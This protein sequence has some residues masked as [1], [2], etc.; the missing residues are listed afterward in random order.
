MQYCFVEGSFA[1]LARELAEYLH[2]EVGDN[3][4]AN[5]KDEVLK[6]LVTAS[7]GLNSYPEKEF[8]A[9]YNLLVYLVMQSPSVNMF[10][11]RIC[12]NLSKPITS[13]PVN[14]AGLALNVLTTIFNLLQPD[15]EVRSNV[16]TAI[17]RLVKNS[18][19]FETLRPQLKKLDTWI[20]EWDLDEEDQRKL[21]GQLAD[22]AEENGEQGESYQYVLKALRTFESA[23][24]SSK[25]AQDL[26]LRALK[27]A[28][29]STTHFDFHDLTSLPT[30]QALSDDHSEY[31]ELLEIFSEKELEDYNDFRDENEDWLETEGLDNSVLHRKMRLLTL[32][33]VAASTNSKEL[34]YKRIAKALQIPVEDVEM[35]VIDVIRAGLIE[36]KLSQQ[37]QV[38]L[39][40]RTTYRVFGEKQWREVATRLD[41]WRSSLRAVKEVISRERQQ[42]EAQKERELHEA[43][44]K[45]AGASGMGAG[46][47]TIGGRENMVEMGTD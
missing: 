35:W 24:Y 37:K 2:V 4:D 39:I 14:G 31:S 23:E 38:F 3:L 45:I 34:E 36:G 13:A 28:L 26:S 17:L 46:R 47:R 30:I 19:N 22:V 29:V 32:A 21:F 44:R 18:G 42:A 16:F 15:N 11:P 12:E 25:E 9:A 1:D 7:A 27:A 10:L 43:E 6:K 20:E 40:H 41:T 5:L 33:S 8:T